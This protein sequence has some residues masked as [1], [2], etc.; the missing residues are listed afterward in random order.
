M[1]TLCITMNPLLVV[2]D[3]HRQ[4]MKKKQMHILEGKILVVLSLDLCRCHDRPL[5]KASQRAAID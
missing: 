3:E 4:G 1:K 5:E 2:I